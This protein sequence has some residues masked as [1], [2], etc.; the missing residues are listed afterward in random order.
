MSDRDTDAME[1]L[2][3]KFGAT[4]TRTSKKIQLDFPGVSES[5]QLSTSDDEL[6]LFA[7][8]WHEHFPDIDSLENF[9]DALFSGRVEIIVTYRGKTPVGHQV[10]VQ[11]DGREEVVSRTA[12]LVPLF[13]KPKSHKTFTYDRP[14]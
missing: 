5:F 7:E 10:R 8:T 4:T 1:R 12:I 6:I 9:L 2:H 14:T 3:Q 13:W 11:R